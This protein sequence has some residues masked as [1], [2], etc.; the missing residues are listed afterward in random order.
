MNVSSWMAKMNYNMQ[1]KSIFQYGLF[2]ETIY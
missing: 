1:Q 2:A